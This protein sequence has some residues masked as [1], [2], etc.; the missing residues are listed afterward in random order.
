[1]LLGVMVYRRLV[2]ADITNAQCVHLTMPFN[3]HAVARVVAVCS[4]AVVVGVDAFDVATRLSIRSPGRVTGR[5]SATHYDSLKPAD[6]TSR[7]HE[8]ES[9]DGIVIA[10]RPDRTRSGTGLATVA[11]IE[12][13]D[14]QCPYCGDYARETYPRILTQF[15]VSGSVDYVWRYFPLEAV[16]PFATAA[17]KAVECASRQERRD[18]M[19]A[20][21]FSYQNSLDTPLF[22]FLANHL[23]LDV[24][25][26]RSCLASAETESIIR[27]DIREAHAAGVNVTPT[28]LIG[29]YRTDRSIL[30]LRRIRGAQRF[31]VFET[32]LR[33]VLSLPTH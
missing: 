30:V 32:A 20:L 19:H 16:H 21:L 13:S 12:F 1:V 7:N 25:E 33:E 3:L 26:F 24:G 4:T 6:V 22:E 9:V 10:S 29:V 17:S 8:S 27:E 15:V 31:E 23:H 14:Y 5:S 28:F 18:Q 2:S 11:M